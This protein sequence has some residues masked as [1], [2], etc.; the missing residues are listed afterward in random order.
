MPRS[1]V[2]FST[3]SGLIC[4]Y[5]TGAVNQSIDTFLGFAAG[6]VDRMLSSQDRQNL[7]E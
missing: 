5:G 1:I 2:L 3:L 6:D 7:P 4:I